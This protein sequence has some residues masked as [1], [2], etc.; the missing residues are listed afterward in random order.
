MRGQEPG[1]RG[2]QNSRGRGGKRET[3]SRI[4]K[5]V[6]T[7]R[8]REKFCNILQLKKCQEAGIP[9]EG[10]VTSSNRN[11]KYEVQTPLPLI[12]LELVLA[13]F[14]WYF[15]YFETFCDKL[16][17]FQIG[18]TKQFASEAQGHP[19]ATLDLTQS[20]SKGIPYLLDKA[21]CSV[22]SAEYL[23]IT[24]KQLP[25]KETDTFSIKG[26]HGWIKNELRVSK[27]ELHLMTTLI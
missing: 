9:K 6:G 19:L 21:K 16:F 14:L 15:I 4:S 18:C 10:A 20:G 1:S 3:R 25:K 11:R 23:N 27:I 12:P 24:W 17:F 26:I 13:C 22:K 8:N 7:G 2:G 5:G